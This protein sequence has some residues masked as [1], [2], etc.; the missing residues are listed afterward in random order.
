MKTLSPLRT[1]TNRLMLVSLVA[2][3]FLIS[4]RDERCD[5]MQEN[6]CVSV[7][8]ASGRIANSTAILQER[9]EK[10]VSGQLSP[11]EK[12]CLSF[13]SSGENAFRVIAV[14]I[15]ND[16][17]ISSEVYSEGGY[18]F[19]ATLKDSVVDVKQHTGY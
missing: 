6:V 2:F 4:C 7:S 16:T 10:I 17:I 15:P 8:N 1:F 12:I 13:K 19:V 9:G 14:F 3:T 5:C 18:K 11:N